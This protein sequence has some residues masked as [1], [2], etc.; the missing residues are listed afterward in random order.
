M[1]NDEREIGL[2]SSILG[3][4]DNLSK[5][6]SDQLNERDVGS[7]IGQGISPPYPPEELASLIEIN[8][9]LD[10]AIRKKA[11]REVGFGF[12]LAKHRNVDDADD[13]EKQTLKD[14]YR[15][16][17]TIYK[18]GPKGTPASSVNEVFEKCRE[19]YHHIG[20]LAME[21]IYAGYDKEPA[22]LAHIPASTV[23]IKRAEDAEDGERKAG[24]GFVQEVDGQT[25]YFSEIGGRQ[26]NDFTETEKY[27]DEET[28]EV[29]NSTQ[30]DREPANE[31]LFVPNPHPNSL[32]Y[33]IPDYISQINTI[34][35][36]QQ[37]RE[38]NS[39]FFEN[40]AI[41]QFMF[42][43]KGGKLSENEREDL[44]GII[45]ATERSRGKT[46][47]SY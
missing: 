29:Y 15:N 28:G 9:T 26:T 21:V 17:Q 11:R 42:L 45:E 23:R 18:T 30:A 32:Y 36:D 24:Y 6:S 13:A 2:K 37:A 12:D 40:D 25:K 10:T 44:R 39:Q 16:P 14:F 46:S 22:G 33:G 19:D 47:S 41:P 7:T 31:I 38:F 5:V 43:V 34:V 1:T 8:G 35:A 3:M 20:W 4:R 27:V